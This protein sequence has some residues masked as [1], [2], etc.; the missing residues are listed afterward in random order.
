MSHLKFHAKIAKFRLKQVGFHVCVFWR[1]N[2]N[3]FGSNCCPLCSLHYHKVR[4]LNNFQ[5]LTKGYYPNLKV[6]VDFHECIRRLPTLTLRVIYSE[7]L[8]IARNNVQ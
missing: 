5:K 8:P 2:S 3:I 1:E 7:E 4:L 6:F